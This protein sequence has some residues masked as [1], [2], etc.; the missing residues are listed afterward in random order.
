[1]KNIL[2][3]FR[4]ELGAYFNS[5]VAYIYAIVFILINNGL[6][7]TRFY[8][9]GRA[10][11]RAYFELLPLTLLIFI[12]VVSMRLWAEDK[13]ENTFELLLTFPMKPLEL[14]LG[15][16]FASVAFFFLSLVAT[17]TIPLVLFMSGTPDPGQ[18]I[19][20]YFGAFLTGILF[21]SIGI[22]TSGLTKEQIVAFVLAAMSCFVIYLLG[23]DFVAVSVD[24]WISGLGSFLKST[25]GAAG[26]LQSFNKGVIDLK[27]IAY[28]IVVSGIFLLLNSFSFEGRL[29]PGARFVF[30]G[31]VVVCV[32]GVILVNWLVRDFAFTRFDVTQDKNYTVSGASKRILKSLKVPVSVKVY[33]TP[34][35]RMP[36][37]YRTLEQDI[38]GKLEELRIIS[39]GRLKFEVHHIEAANLL[40]EK[41][42]PAEGK[43]AGALERSLAE[44]GISPFQVESIDKDEMGFKLIYSALSVI[45]KEKSEEILPRIVP[46]S[47]PDLEYLLLSRIVKLTRER[48]PKIVLYSSLKE[49]APSAELNKILSSMKESG[50]KYVDE[51]QSITGLMRSNGYE[52]ERVALTKDSTIPE[53]ADTLVVLNPGPLKDRPLYEINRFLSRGGNLFLGAQGFEYVFSLKPPSGYEV[54][55]QKLS[56]DINKIL[57]KWGMK[58]DDRMLM[59]DN[60]KVINLATGQSI[61]PFSVSMPIKVPNQIEVVQDSMDARAPFMRRLPPLFYIW[62]SALELSGQI[63]EDLGL[64]SKVLFTSGS[65]SW[66]VSYRGSSLSMNDMSSDAQELVSRLP[67]AVLVEGVFPNTFDKSGVPA[68]EAD[69]V[70]QG[71]SLNLS[72]DPKPGKMVLVGSSKMFTDDLIS[73]PGNLNF[74]ANIV[75]GL[76]LGEDL[77]L[78]RSKTPMSRQLKKLTSQQKAFQRFLALL[79]IPLVLVCVLSVRLFFRGKE[80]QFYLM[81]QGL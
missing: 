29:R 24:G 34:V 1:M 74:F 14:T 50:Q 80:K 21:L 44:K 61:G 18:I 66:F 10:E 51:Y 17:A 27:D 37:T 68:W 22:F 67:L 52:V 31:A 6:F 5:A 40:P 43:E 16:F 13:K 76:T 79:L 19:S 20:G 2:T 42:Q 46:Q 38:V 69:Q 72:F 70:Q 63:Q 41:N 78:I 36:T 56:L 3:V 30:S 81:A 11:M 77:T 28:F 57:E 12:P 71:R 32:M 4:R 53:D 47:L 25:I 45:Y 35:D 58:I 59:D 60:S 48:R 62:G 33:I 8:L 26:H 64:K 23:T 9:A 39:G 55:P 49:E 7:M 73:T 75:D 15:K 54:T 65:K